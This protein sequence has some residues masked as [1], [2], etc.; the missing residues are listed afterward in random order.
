MNRTIAVTA[1]LLLI[2]LASSLARGAEPAP[3]GEADWPDVPIAMG[4]LGGAYFLA[5]PGELVVDLVKRDRNR[6][7]RPAEMRVLLVG[8]DR[9]VLQEATLPDDGR[10]RGGGLG[11]VQRARLSAR[12]DRKGVYG[13]N[14]SVS[15][16]RYGDE[17]FWGLRT[18]CPRYLIE[19]ARGHRDERHQ[20]PI[21]LAGLD[22]P[23]DVCFLP[24]RGA[25]DVEI[26]GASDA[27]PLSMYDAKGTLV[28]TLEVD[29]SGRASHAFPAGANRDAVPWRL[30]LPACQGTIHVDGLTRWESSD[31][32]PDVCCWT[33]EPSSHFSLLEYRWLLTPYGK[34]VYGRA[35][36]QGEA[37]FEVHNNS[38]RERTIELSIEFPGSP[39]PARLS[40]E[41]VTL[42][43]KRA[44]EVTVRYTVPAQGATSECHVRATPVE[45]AEFST[46]STL[47]VRE[48]VAPATRPLAMPLVLEPYRHE[49]EQ[50]GYR[51]DYPVENQ[52]YFAPDNRP[53]TMTRGGVTSWNGDAWVTTGLRTAVRSRDAELEGRS[54]GAASSKVAFDRDGGVYLVATS[55]RQAAL[56]HSTD[57]AKSFSAYAIPS[58]AGRSRTFDIEQFSGHNVPEG[59]PPILR[60]T[61]TASDA[62]SRLRWRR[63][64][65]LELFVPEKVDGGVS[66]G[67]PV[68]VSTQ[69]I[70]L[71]AHSGIP[72]S[73]VSR[74]SK[75]HV[76]WG[77]AT[78]PGVKVPGVPTYV[79][80]YDR[81]TKTLGHPAL[82]GYGAPPN[83]VHNS[84]SITM[85][86]RG[87]LHA[88]AGTHGQPFPYARS[89]E[90]NDAHSGWTDA[91]PVGEGLSQTYIG[92][93]CGPDDALHLVYRL[94]WRGAEPFP[95]S[96]YATLAYQRKP[97]GKPW[98]APR[99]L[100]VPPFSEYSVF[101]HRL[102]IDHAGRLFVSYDYWST[103]WF[104][105]NDH[106][107]SRRAL[108]MSPD[109][110]ETWKLADGGDLR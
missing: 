51:P 71:S 56:L 24:R 57:G 19:T 99:V 9:K 60:Y 98:E 59:P 110:G 31:L 92:M 95:L 106:R 5:E 23:G 49:N 58:R 11:P 3:G 47:T 61:Q 12:V 17:V 22:R 4:G 30:H 7:G 26:T 63:V 91:E 77:E 97:A 94:W 93:V 40:A 85:D 75:V 2:G 76:I 104:Y 32:C 42:R 21:V 16:D 39:W 65:D 27:G 43:A 67:E 66:L 86:S 73:V 83:D 78:D 14:V 69:C 44:T 41:R 1:V 29:S 81:R 8:P 46:Y 54:F 89:L 38:D 53:S 18:N 35:G 36:E 103:L 15:Q 102:T 84:P 105:R 107:G 79:A 64:N 82:V 25:F 48:G 37:A 90:P 100:I 72:A 87:Y 68:L 20:E 101:Y 52:M 88:L 109:G 33:P 34:T 108:M 62:D 70:G 28:A 96:H 6:S 13:L 80:T 50:F 55:G 10:P 45:D 74:G